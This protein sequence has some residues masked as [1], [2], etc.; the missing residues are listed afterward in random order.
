[1]TSYFWRFTPAFILATAFCTNCVAEEG[2]VVLQ[3]KGEAYQ[4]P[5]MAGDHYIV[6]RGDTLYSI[7]R[8]K[9]GESANMP[10]LS[11]ATVEKNPHAFVRG[12]ANALMAGKKI[13]L[14]NIPETVESR[15]DAIYFF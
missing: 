1:M 13:I 7:L 14:P 6:K 12:N 4:N 2:F 10:A 5:I 9:F 8:S 15:R 3:Y 11:S